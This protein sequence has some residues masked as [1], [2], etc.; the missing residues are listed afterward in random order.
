MP[1]EPIYRLPPYRIE[2]VLRALAETID[3]G[4][5]VY[6]VPEAW[7]RSRGRGIRSA[8]LDTGID[9][10]H[11]DLQGSVLATC[12]FT[13][14]GI[15][16]VSGHGTHCAGVIAARQNDLGVVGICPD[17]AADGGG[18]LIG[19]VLGNDGAGSESWIGKGIDWAVEQGAHL[20]SMSLGSPQYSAVMFQ[21][22]YRAVA[23]GV[24][25]ICAAGN[26]GAD[27][28]VDYP[29][30]FE[31][32]ITVGAVDRNGHVAS[33]SSRGPE[34]DIA[35]PGQDVLSTF[36]GGR[37]AKLSG[38]SMATPFVAGVVALMLSKHKSQGSDTPIKT[39]EQLREHL[40][41][42]ATDAGSPGKDPSYGYGLI[43]PLTMLGPPA[44][45]DL[46]P[47]AGLRWDVEIAGAPA[48]F[49]LVPHESRVT[50]D[51]VFHEPRGL[52]P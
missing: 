12:D 8:V 39:V 22:I 52:R 40:S 46:P 32:T 33:F 34:V 36:P 37:Y 50:I 17:L 2:V 26:N 24:F 27:N 23:R 43:N 48:A 19:K 6:G 10:A 38:T 41:R 13:G 4:L 5:A 49:V 47:W 42:T 25:V 21:A 29:G 35:A 31:E 11:P 16:D 45:I 44:P 15:N 3:W 18:L 28:S 20:I 30:K 14:T 7:T 1:R 9:L 51:P